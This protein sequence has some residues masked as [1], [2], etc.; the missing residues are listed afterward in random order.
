MKRIWMI[1]AVLCMMG[2]NAQALVVSTEEFGEISAEG[3]EI[4]IETAEEDP[5]TGKPVMEV[6]GSLLSNGELSVTIAR[7]AAGLEDEFCCAGQCKSGNGE[8]EELIHYNVAEMASWYIHYTPKAGS[9]ET[10]QYTFSD[11]EE[12][13]VLTVHYR[14][15]AQG[16]DEV[17]EE[18]KV[19]KVLQDGIL[20]IIKDNVVY[21]L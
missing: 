13:L 9:N 17:K 5:L 19:Q 11:G 21:N 14:Y 18:N 4:T 2:L 1:S 10:I 20:Y 12:S 16:I 15:E 6:K 8:M 7:S 3:L